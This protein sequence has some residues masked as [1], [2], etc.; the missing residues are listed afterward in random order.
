MTQFSETQ[1]KSSGNRLLDLLPTAESQRLLSRLELV[2][3][4]LKTI[5]TDVGETSRDVFF[6]I[7][8]V[9]SAVVPLRD[10][11]SIEAGAVGREG[12]V[13]VE[14]IARPAPSVYQY[15]QQVEGDALRMPAKEFRAI[16]AEGGALPELLKRYALT[17]MHQSGQTAACNVR[18]T[19]EERMCRWLLM[20]HDRV[21]RDEFYVTQEFLGVMLGVRRQ[22]VSLTASTLQR[23][24]L[25]EYMRGNVKVLNRG[26][27][28][29]SACECYGTVQEMYEQ[30]MQQPHE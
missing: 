27:I 12:L 11:S 13:G 10:G 25:I 18:H 19:V 26:G 2:Q 21:V 1:P 9:I 15:V 29:Q 3:T 14:L 30:V 16:L 7:S 20:T 28:E 5:V 22:S 6:P 23:A 17:V 4:P 24:G 8:C